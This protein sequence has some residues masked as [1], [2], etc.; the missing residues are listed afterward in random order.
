MKMTTQEEY[1]LRCLLRLGREAEG[2]SLTISELSRQEGVAMPTVA[3]MMRI[4]RKAG[5]VRSTRGK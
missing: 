2:H 1:G 5:L 3:K 4:L